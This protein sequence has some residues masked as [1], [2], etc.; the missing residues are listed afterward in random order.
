MVHRWLAWTTI[1]LALVHA[2]AAIKHHLWDGKRTLV[3]M[4]RG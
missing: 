3:R 1:A 2:A 4:L